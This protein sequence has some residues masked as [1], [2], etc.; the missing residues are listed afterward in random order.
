MNICGEYT[1]L[2][3]AFLDG[4]LAPEEMGGVQ[5]HL[6]ACPACRAASLLPRA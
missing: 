6:E 2:L 5:S 1:A 3:D 4:E